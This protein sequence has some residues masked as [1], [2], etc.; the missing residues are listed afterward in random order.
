MGNKA[1]CTVF[2]KERGRRRNPCGATCENF[3]DISS[4]AFLGEMYNLVFDSVTK[5]T[6]DMYAQGQ[7]RVAFYMAQ[8]RVPA[9][10][11][12]WGPDMAD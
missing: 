11:A 4:S 12:A 5:A 9:Y 10:D 6:K 8:P 2:T 3:M 1:V 7:G